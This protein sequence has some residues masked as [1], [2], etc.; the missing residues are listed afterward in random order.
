MVA[1]QAAPPEA[2]R[3]APGEMGDGKW[4]MGDGRWEMGDGRGSLTH[5]HLPSPIY[6]L[7]FRAAPL[8]AAQSEGGIHAHS[9][10]RGDQ[11][12]CDCHGE[13]N[14]AYADQGERVSRGDAE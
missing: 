1:A 7:P 5:F 2:A 9:P 4:E 11:A 3:Q 12:G 14:T 13:Q 10:S 8:G 6:H